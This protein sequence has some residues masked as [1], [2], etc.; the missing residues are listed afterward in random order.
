MR[1][2][3]TIKTTVRLA[4]D[5][6]WRFQSER[7][8]RRLSNEQAIRDAL[9]KWIS[10]APTGASHATR[11]SLKEI[12]VADA[13]ERQCIEDLLQILRNAGNPERALAVKATIGALCGREP[14]D[15]N[16]LNHDD[17]HHGLPT[18]KERLYGVGK[19]T[20]SVRKR[21]RSSS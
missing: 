19:R 16:P 2:K 17:R 18:D 10:A 13:D 12:R 4:A 5:L 1:T 11:S 7:A 3:D 6:H 9:F 14:R 15:A 20:T 21:Q 8:K